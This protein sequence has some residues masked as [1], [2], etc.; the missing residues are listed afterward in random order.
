MQERAPDQFIEI[1]RNTKVLK[2]N[3]GSVKPISYVEL[4][5]LEETNHY[6]SGHRN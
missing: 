6:A 1:E 5:Q 4:V 3:E 2:T